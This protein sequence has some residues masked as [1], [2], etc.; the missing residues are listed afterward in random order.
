MVDQW[1]EPYATWYNETDLKELAYSIWS[2]WDWDDAWED[3]TTYGKTPEEN[4]NKIYS[5]LKAWERDLLY[6][7]EECDEPFETEWI[8]WDEYWLNYSR[9]DIIKYAE[10]RNDLWNYD[11]ERL[12]EFVQSFSTNNWLKNKPLSEI[13]DEFSM[14][15]Y[16]EELN[17]YLNNIIFYSFDELVDIIM[18]WFEKEKGVTWDRWDC[19][20]LASKFVDLKELYDLNYDD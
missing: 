18:K 19:A 10:T 3:E 2:L 17:D 5:L 11:I 7:V 15:D 20:E 8:C 4:V 14:L 12:I 1:G 16:Q 13:L 6:F 9:E